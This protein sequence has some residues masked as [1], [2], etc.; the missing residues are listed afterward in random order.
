MG[1][2]ENGEVVLGDVTSTDFKRIKTVNDLRQGIDQY[3]LVVCAGIMNRL[4][5]GQRTIDFLLDNFTHPE[6]KVIPSLNVKYYSEVNRVTGY[7]HIFYNVN[8]KVSVWD[9]ESVANWTQG[10]IYKIARTIMI[11]LIDFVKTSCSESR[12]QELMENAR[13]ELKSSMEYASSLIGEQVSS[14]DELKKLYRGKGLREHT[15]VFKAFKR[16]A[17]WERNVSMGEML[18]AGI[19]VDGG[20]MV[21][22]ECS[23]NIFA[24]VEDNK[25][26]VIN[27]YGYRNRL[28]FD[29]GNQTLKDYILENCGIDTNNPL[30]FIMSGGNTE[31]RINSDKQWG[32]LIRN[33]RSLKEVDES[34]LR[35]I[36]AQCNIINHIKSNIESSYIYDI[37]TESMSFAF[38]NNI[39]ISEAIEIMSE[40]IEKY[41][42]NIFETLSIDHKSRSVTKYWDLEMLNV[43][44][45]SLIDRL[46]RTKDIETRLDAGIWFNRVKTECLQGVRA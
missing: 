8:N 27:V 43:I 46:D 18:S 24:G 6:D 42:P 2:E 17:Y 44:P 10:Q 41:M 35:Y 34:R 39:K 36:E 4:F 20:I 40:A 38:R 19:S 25:Y 30:E 33:S 37:S 23:G 22:R 1:L 29:K 3:D 9:T 28:R 15:D 16:A 5:N 11:A 32:K 45:I 12:Y 13:G 31:F 7:K 14:T 26:Y 21:S